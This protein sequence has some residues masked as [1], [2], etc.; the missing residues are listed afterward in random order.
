MSQ[1]WLTL[2]LYLSIR[3]LTI[4]LFTDKTVSEHVVMERVRCVDSSRPSADR[5]EEDGEVKH[6]QGPQVQVGQG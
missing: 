2:N 6:S 3:P 5:P 4:S 1:G